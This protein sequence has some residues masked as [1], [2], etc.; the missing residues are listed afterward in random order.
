MKHAVWISLLIAL[1]VVN[2]AAELM[3]YFADVYVAMFYRIVLITAITLIS[4][5]FV[6]ALALVRLLNEEK[7]LSGQVSDTLGEDRKKD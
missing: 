7:P 6:G 3:Y 4:A 2:V 1:I 5:I